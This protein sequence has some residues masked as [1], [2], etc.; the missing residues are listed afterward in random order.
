MYA[1]IY[2]LKWLRDWEM[3]ENGVVFFLGS[4]K[5]KSVLESLAGPLMS[6]RLT[7]LRGPRLF[8]LFASNLLHSHS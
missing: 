5:W 6:T 4:G 2:R 8:E 1:H 7:F 3:V